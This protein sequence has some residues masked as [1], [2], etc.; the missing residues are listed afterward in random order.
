VVAYLLLV[1][2]QLAGLALIPFGLPGLWVQVGALAVFAWATGFATVGTYPVVLVVL[3]ALLAE[4]AEFL[5]AGR[6]A[7]RYGGGR[8]AAAGALVGGVAGALLG[9]P[10]PLVGSVVGAMLGS[11][12]G[13]ALL[14]LT[15][16]RGAHP[17]LR[18]GW[19]A[20]LGRVVAM[21]M[22]GGLGVVVAVFSL[23]TAL[24]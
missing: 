1:L 20:F 9:I 14:E 4:T 12:V 15:T 17:A 5:L 2:A 3:L 13:A 16:G 10:I 11:F 7:R 24:R 21:A 23:F 18:A 8:R 6:Y 19:G 22:K